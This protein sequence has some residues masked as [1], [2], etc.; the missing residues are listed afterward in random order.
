MC[1]LIEQLKHKF[2][3]TFFNEKSL[4]SSAQRESPVN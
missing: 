1:E 4:V 2:N 3:A